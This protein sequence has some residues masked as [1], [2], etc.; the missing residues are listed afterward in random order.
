MW[1]FNYAFNNDSVDDG[2][3]NECV[4]AG[5]WELSAGKPAPVSLLPLQIHMTWPG[6]EQG[7]PRWEA[8]D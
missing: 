5:E 6:M 3:I 4:A 1:S 7:Q 2:I 8:G